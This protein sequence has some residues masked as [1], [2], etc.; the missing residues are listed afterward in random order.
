[1]NL[2]KGSPCDGNGGEVVAEGYWA[3][4]GPLSTDAQHDFLCVDGKL[5]GESGMTSETIVFMVDTG[6]DMQVTT[7]AEVIQELQL[8]FK[9]KVEI[10]GVHT[11][12][13]ADCYSAT[14]LIGNYELEVEVRTTVREISPKQ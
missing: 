2:L 1:M 10:R 4:P 13:P 14:L 11:A 12:A 7:K 3:R 5:R 9:R 8:P 6:S